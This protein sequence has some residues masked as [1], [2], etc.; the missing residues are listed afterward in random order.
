MKDRYRNFWIFDKDL[1]LMWR[2]RARPATIRFP[3]DIDGDG[4][5][6]FLIG[7]SLWEPDGKR[8]WSHD[9]E[10]KD[11][12]DGSR[13]ATSADD[14]KRG[15]RVYIGGMRRRLSH[16]RHATASC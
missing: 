11:H 12:A 16:V 8:R 9:A 4:R 10:L 6:E 7:Y 14:P 5:E 2:G 13:S 15:L 1:K 3:I